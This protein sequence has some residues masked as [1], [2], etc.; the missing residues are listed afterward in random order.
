VTVRM[1]YRM[2]AVFGADRD[3]LAARLA[4][5]RLGGADRGVFELACVSSDLTSAPDDCRAAGVLDL[6][7]LDLP[8]P[9][10]FGDFGTYAF[11]LVS[12]LG[13]GGPS[14]LFE[15]ESFAS[16]DWTIA[17]VQYERAGFPRVVTGGVNAPKLSM[18]VVELGEQ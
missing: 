5:W 17:D 14:R 1:A 4:A 13:C 8:D 2:V 9:C 7:L 3:D 18:R 10:G 6:T 15:I 11:V 12:D 16:V